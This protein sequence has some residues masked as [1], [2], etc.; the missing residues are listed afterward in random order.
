MTDHRPSPVL[1]DGSNAFAHRSMAVRLPGIV[2]ETID[3]NPDYP[4]RVRDGLRKLRDDLVE[5]APL[6]LFEPSTPDYELWAD[7]FEAYR[8]DTWLGT[9]W[10]FAEMLAYRLMVHVVR[11][12]DTLRD[13]FAPFK[14]EE[15][16]SE[17]LWEALEATLGVEG[18]LEERLAAR[19]SH[20]L[21]G[22]RIDLSVKQ[23]AQQGTRAHADHLLRDDTPAAVRHLMHREPGTV[24]FIMDNAGTEQ[25]MDLAVV[26]LLLGEGVAADVVLHVKMQPVLVSD[27]L[28]VDV[29][30]LIERMRARSGTAA[31][32]ARRLQAYREDGAL[33]IVPDFF[34]STD[35]RLWELPERLRLA[36]R[37]A[38]LVISKGDANYRRATND[39]LW[40]AGT[41]LAEA[42]RGF[43]A[44]L[45]ALRTLKSDTLVG[46]DAA[47]IARLD[48]TAGK[49]WR[50]RGTYGVAQFT[51]GDG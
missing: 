47:T 26:D 20:A 31:A 19:L 48:Q 12:W 46:V 10:F 24:H 38:R 14:E 18:S 7:R 32:L 37:T 6:P 45:L 1:T 25:A 5:D 44:P 51:V 22:N 23:S 33:R 39:A 30:R 17:A 50:T 49:D 16:Q 21:W 4:P 11:Y 13:P 36:F 29:H 15:Q 9:E 28:V 41:T 34:W 43:P 27:A 42:I 8:G 40:D 35:G 3:R 2:Q